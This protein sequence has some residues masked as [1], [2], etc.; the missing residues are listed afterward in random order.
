MR[1]TKSELNDLCLKYDVDRLYSW[2]R[3]NKYKT[4][5]YEYYLSYISSHKPDRET[6]IYG[7][8]GN[9][10]HQIL[11]DLYG[12]KIKYDN[13]IEEFEDAW[14]TLEIADLKFD[15]S[16]EEK[17][18]KIK[19]KYVA[20]LRHFFRNHKFID[21]KVDLERFI[22]IKVGKYVFQGYI[23]LVRKS[24]DGSYIIQ[25]YKTS[26]IY[27]GDKAIKEAGQL[28]L[29]AMGLNQLGIP[30]DKLKICWNFLKYC[31]VTICQANGKTNEREIERSKIGESLKSNAKMWM[32]KLGHEDDID[33]YLDLLLQTN[34]IAC[35]PDDVQ[36]KYIFDDCYVYVELTQDMFDNLEGKIINTLDEI[37]EKENKYKTTKD[38]SLFWDSEESMSSQSYYFA[39]LC[40]W[41]ANLHKPYKQ[42]LEMLKEK[43]EGMNGVFVGVGGHDKSEINTEDEDLSWLKD[44]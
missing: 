8:S 33:G 22:I 14:T 5:Q 13:M 34:D 1:K 6:S 7:S 44:L 30:L 2:S 20:D 35:L 39:N 9:Y 26:S 10:A 42:Y 38:D 16:N 23:D 41:S 29:Y 3:Y 21:T 32:K 37:I 40:G 43:K 36:E 31:K 24:D 17:N 4:S 15:R 28:I 11:E 27:K 25:D 12:N 18:E 19:E